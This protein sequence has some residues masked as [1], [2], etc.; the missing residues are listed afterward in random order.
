MRHANVW[1]WWVVIWLRLSLEIDGYCQNGLVPGW[2]PCNF[3]QNRITMQISKIHA[4]L[5]KRSIRNIYCVCV[6]ACVSFNGWAVVVFSAFG[7]HN[8][9][10]YLYGR[11]VLKSVMCMRTRV[12]T[13]VNIA[14]AHIHALP[15]E[16]NLQFI[17][18][19]TAGIRTI[20]LLC[21]I[22]PV[23]S[24]NFAETFNVEHAYRQ[25]HPQH[26]HYWETRIM[27]T[28]K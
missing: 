25:Q 22:T 23:V 4:I 18:L 6:F 26:R 12:N 1:W 21:V 10:K 15:F 3:R 14:H 13:A 27:A 9:A 11:R 20:S 28:T 8:F 24:A 17:L 7:C 5:K 16:V 19:A 2:L